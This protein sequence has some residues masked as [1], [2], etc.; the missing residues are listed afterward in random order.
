MKW[1]KLYEDFDKSKYR[2][3][4]VI[5]CIENGG[6][7]YAEIIKDFPNNDPSA[8]LRPVSVDENGV[9]TVEYE[10]DLYEV[11]LKDVDKI[12]YE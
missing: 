7:V 5:R 8:P 2:I 3:E 6:S 12:E 1:L 9:V 4:D 10:D 11:D